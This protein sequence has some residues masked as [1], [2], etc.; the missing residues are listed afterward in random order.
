MRYSL[1]LVEDDV[2]IRHSITSFLTRKGYG[3]V[4]AGTCAEAERAFSTGRPDLALLDYELPDGNALRLLPG[5]RD[6]DVPVVILSGNASVERA[7]LA[8]KEGAEHFLTK[9][10]ELS[11]LLSM[12]Q[13][14]LENQRN[15]HK[16]LVAQTGG[17]REAPDPFIGTSA[18]I[19][20]L[21]M[22]AMRVAD[23]DSAVLVTGE[24]GSGKGVLARWL[25]DHGPRA[26]EAFVDLNCAGLAKDLL[27]SDLFG[28]ERGAFTGAASAK[29]GL[30]EIAH[31][32]TVFLDEIGDVD[33]QVQPRLLKV[34]EERRFRRLG[35]VR[36]RMVDIRLIAAT[37]HDLGQLAREKRFREDLYFRI[38]T[39]P[40]RVPPLRERLEDLPELSA[41]LLDRLDGVRGRARLSEAALQRL[42]TYPWPGNIREL[43]NVLERAVILSQSEVL[44]PEDLRFD[45]QIV[46]D[47]SDL[48]LEAAERRH[49]ERVVKRAGSV[50]AA[51]HILRIP[52][53]TLYYK[54][55]KN[56]IALPT[57]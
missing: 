44:G 7:V 14:T 32:G 25:H 47:D 3:V 29:Q 35:D 33:A 10:V 38:S 8:I 42:R 4:D 41:R 20:A 46:A 11:A 27:E 17:Q 45:T 36:D 2:L 50:A 31:R 51:A 34:L 56:R 48:S 53:S 30:L 57:A 28:H 19:R 1:L 13:R 54:L 39:L 55:K 9:P 40:L 24:T 6:S 43:R 52:K 37:H 49:I 22:D 21:R 16:Q 5:L 15:R 18:A 26:T 12:I 23:A